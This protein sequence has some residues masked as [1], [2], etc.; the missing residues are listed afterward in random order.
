M[1]TLTRD[2]FIYEMN[3][4]NP[5][6]MR[7]KPMET[8]IVETS[9]CFN[10]QIQAEGDVLANTDFECF[11][12]AT[13]PIYIE[14]AQKGDIIKVYIEDINIADSGVISVMPEFGVTGV[15][16]KEEKTK[17]IP[18]KDGKA[19]FNDYISLDIDP[20]IGVIGTAPE[21]KSIMTVVPDA[22]GGNMDCKRITKGSTVFLPSNVEGALL[23]LGDLH[24]V[25]GDGEVCG[26]GVE[27]K[28]E[29]TLKVEV[30]KDKSLPLPLILTNDVVMTVASHEDL[31]EAASW[32]TKN[33]Y[34]LLVNKL[35]MSNEEASMLLSIA[36]DLRVNQ[37]VNPLKTARFEIKKDV[38]KNYKFDLLV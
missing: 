5:P 25:M 8:F 36:G 21:D 3:S 31:N 10:G 4:D 2:K 11:N 26:C 24:A 6:Q 29:V 32:V 28:G 38:F 17:I 27:I 18:I 22:H 1:K 15:Y 12:P 9:D 35:D 34:Q 19:V 20:M 13:G 7:V 30:L 37:L 16:H 33:M 14:G 23:S